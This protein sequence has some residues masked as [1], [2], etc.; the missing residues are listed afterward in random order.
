MS[1]VCRRMQKVFLSWLFIMM[2]DGGSPGIRDSSIL[3]SSILESISQRT[4]DKDV[5]HYIL[6]L[7]HRIGWR[8]G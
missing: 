8:F 2:G 4:T 7:E 5:R 6:F 1:H 3:D